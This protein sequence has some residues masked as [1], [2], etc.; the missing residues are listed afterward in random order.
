MYC[1]DETR[2]LSLQQTT[3]ERREF[4]PGK[5]MGRDSERRAESAWLRNSLEASLKPLSVRRV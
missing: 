4:I 5:N 2:K 1:F 3:L